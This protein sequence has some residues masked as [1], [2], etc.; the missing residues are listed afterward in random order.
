MAEEDAAQE[1]EA[2]LQAEEDKMETEKGEGDV[3][4]KKEK[5]EIQVPEGVILTGSL[6]FEVTKP[7]PLEDLNGQQ[8]QVELGP[9]N[10]IE[11]KIIKQME[12]YFGDFNLPR[13]RFL[14]EQIKEDPDGWVSLATMTKFNR[15]KSLSTSL[16]IIST[17]IRKSK[18][19]LIEV[20][21]DN[22]Y[23]RRTPEKPLPDN[24]EER[25]VDILNRSVYAKGFPTNVSLDKLMAYFEAMGPTDSVFMRR[26]QDRKFKGSVFVTFG[27]QALANKFLKDNSANYDGNPLVRIPK[28]QY[29]EKQM[30]EKKE[31]R[32]ERLRIK[33]EEQRKK[34]EEEKQKLRATITLGTILHL[35]N[36]S[37]ETEREDVKNYFSDYATVAWVD[38]DKGDQEAWVRFDGE[39]K[40][41]DAMKEAQENHDGKIEI[42]GTVQEACVLEGDEELEHW[43]KIF[44][45]QQ[46]K[47]K[48]RKRKGR[49]DRSE[50]KKKRKESEGESGDEGEGD[51]AAEEEEAE[52]DDAE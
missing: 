42:N 44:Q 29:H 46:D 37:E 9:P 50:G 33:Q 27:T 32:L 3:D 36:M 26:D 49:D 7:K 35:K 40:A 23:V 39:N 34:L 19:N 15:L 5:N 1:I 30:E 45:E 13:D 48:D 8:E 52:V 18:S 6:D 28:Q 20:S 51:E 16:K 14:Q 25:R 47:R 10:K 43:R 31:R 41:Y 4:V 17:A 11:L 22:V 38:F 21:R 2:K 12:Y 24:S